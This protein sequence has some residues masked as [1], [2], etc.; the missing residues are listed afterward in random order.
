MVTSLSSSVVETGKGQIPIFNGINV[1]EDNLTVYDEGTW[2]PVVKIGSTVITVSGSYATFTRIGNRV[3]ITGTIKFNRASNSGDI[4]IEGLPVAAAT[5]SVGVL[6]LVGGDKIDTTPPL[7]AT[8]AAGTQVIALRKTGGSTAANIGNM[9][10]AQV[11]ASTDVEVYI[12]GQY[13]V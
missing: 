4:T 5:S 12:S 7:R 1:G 9:S 6:S 8:I 2:T 10:D 13:E 3:F 11:A